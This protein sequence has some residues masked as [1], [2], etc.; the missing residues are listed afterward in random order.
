[1]GDCLWYNYHGGYRGVH[2]VKL[3]KVLSFLTIAF[4]LVTTLFV[5]TPSPLYASTTLNLIV[6]ASSDDCVVYWNGSAWVLSLT[7]GNGYVGSA[8]SGTVDYCGQGLRFTGATI[9]EDA[10]IET[11]YITFQARTSISTTTV[12]GDF[13]GGL[14]VSDYATSY[15]TFSNISNYQT[16]RGTDVGGANNDYLTSASVAWS[17]ISAWT[18]STDYQSPEL[19]T[20]I[21]EQVNQALWPDD[22][23]GGVIIIYF[24][25]HDSTNRS[26]AGACRSARTYNDNTTYCA[27]L[28]IEY[29]TVV[30]PTVTK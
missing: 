18:A 7:N 13:R 20:I 14:A 12:N 27:R 2:V 29:S 30:A 24:D 11:A 1:M 3:R 17:S 19:K 9:P 10:T 4:L 23:T 16:R 22:G 15:A 25:D 8:A 26:T 5:A 21:Q 6:G 28:H